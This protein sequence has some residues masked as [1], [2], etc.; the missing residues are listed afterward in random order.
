MVTE[1]NHVNLR[2]KHLYITGNE[3]KPDRQNL[4]NAI[5]CFDMEPQATTSDNLAIALCTYFEGHMDRPKPDPQTENGW[6]TWAEGQANRVLDELTDFVLKRIGTAQQPNAERIQHMETVLDD[7]ADLL[8]AAGVLSEG[9]RITAGI[10]RLM[11]R[12]AQPSSVSQATWAKALD[13]IGQLAEIETD[14]D[15][16]VAWIREAEKF[17]TEHAPQLSKEVSDGKPSNDAPWPPALLSDILAWL[18]K[19]E[20]RIVCD[21][22]LYEL[23]SL[24]CHIRH[25]D[26]DELLEQGLIESTPNGRAYRITE[27]GRARLEFDPYEG[28]DNGA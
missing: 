27:A 6:G 5:G 17:F 28:T 24:G 18:S 16:A 22:G 21:D 19:P 1:V 7:A 13:I 2:A 15:D 25:I 11:E 9:E 3:P 4:R 23:R 12:A 20:W 10:Q 8:Q 14:D 26:V